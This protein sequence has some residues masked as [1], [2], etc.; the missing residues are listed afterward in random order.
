MSDAPTVQMTAVPRLN[1]SNEA[2]YEELR[3]EFGFDP[4]DRDD[5]SYDDYNLAALA[6]TEAILRLRGLQA[7]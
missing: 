2:F 1:P 7:E 3:E 6:Y 5:L 4:L